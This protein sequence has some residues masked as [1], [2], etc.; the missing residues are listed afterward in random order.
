MQRAAMFR[1]LFFAILMASIAWLACG[2][3]VVDDFTEDTGLWTEFDP[4]RRIERDYATDNRLEFAGWIRP[5]LGYV[6][7]LCRTQD[8]VL[9]FDIRITDSG[10]NAK[11]I[12]PGFSDNLATIDQ[13]QNGIHVVYYAGCPTE[14]SRLS[15]NT[16]VNGVQEWG[17]GGNPPQPN[18]IDISRNVTYYVR[19]EKSGN[20][21]TLGIF[22]DPA[23][24]THIEGSPKTVTTAL[25]GTAFN[26]LYAVNGYTT[27]PIGNW[28][29][30][31]GW[32]DNI[33]VCLMGMT[34]GAGVRSYG[35]LVAGVLEVAM[36]EYIPGPL[37]ALSGEVRAMVFGDEDSYSHPGLP[38]HYE[39]G[40]SPPIVLATEVGAGGVVA[41][42]CEGLFTP[43]NIRQY[44]NL[45]LG[46]NIVEWLARKG[47][48]NVLYD[49]RSWPY[50]GY[51]G[52][53]VYEGLGV[54]LLDADYAV[55]VHP[56]GEPVDP[57]TLHDYDV[58]MVCTSWYPFSEDELHAIGMFVANGGGLLLTG[59]G[60]SWAAYQGT[61]E[62]Y[63][64]NVIAKGFGMKF[65]DGYVRDPT[66]NIDGEDT[67]PLFHRFYVSEYSRC[68]NH[69]ESEVESHYAGR[70]IDAKMFLSPSE[71]DI[72]NGPFGVSYAITYTYEFA[73]EIIRVSALPIIHQLI[74][75]IEDGLLPA[76]DTTYE[77]I[78]STFH[79]KNETAPL[80]ERCKA[81]IAVKVL[82]EAT[83]A[84]GL[85]ESQLMLRY[86]KKEG[87]GLWEIS[88][89][90]CQEGT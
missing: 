82:Q 63:P 51:G 73:Q 23:R 34:V 4:D 8:F 6:S 1:I 71:L 9:D 74:S 18:R 80:E 5:E 46:F 36:P 25:S 29:W 13:V 50:T 85:R 67:Y 7:T 26:Y 55:D 35:D 57:S 28:E 44:D 66:H 14:S 83:T 43:A 47:N 78:R 68:R 38:G 70:Y 41:C 20:A 81:A 31:T 69:S 52:A 76:L 49:G 88:T 61:L 22:L 11:I 24:T 16:R 54:A 19:L 17:A 77:E 59:L 60:W 10:G 32:I 65:M 58:Y 30:T 72:L 42:S 56:V 40:E 90:P 48:R 27:S 37:L 2:T 84:D 89:Q 53:G 86:S 75:S 39:P 21:L 64:M 87:P 45:R 3:C 33:S 15:I 62:E 79:V 12:G